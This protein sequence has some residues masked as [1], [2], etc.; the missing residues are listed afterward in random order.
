MLR[1]AL[2][3]RTLDAST[4]IRA[5]TLLIWAEA[6]FALGREL[7]EDMQGLFASDFRIEYLPNTSHWVMEER[8]EV[9]NNLLLDFLL[10]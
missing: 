1:D 8:P 10:A 3:G 4:I 2:T 5:P 7:T 9:V 6:D